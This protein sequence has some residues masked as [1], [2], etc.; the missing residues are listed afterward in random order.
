MGTIYIDLSSRTLTLKV[1]NQNKGHFPVAIGKQSTPTP[2]GDFKILSKIRN[3]GGVLGTRW[4]KFTHREHGIHG[5]NQPQLIG[6]AVSNGCVRMYNRDAEKVYGSVKINSPVIIRNRLSS[7]IE[8]SS[9]WFI[10]TVKPGDTL[11]KLSRKY[12]TT[13]ARLKKINHLNNQLLHPGQKIKIPGNQ[14]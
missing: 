10:Y 8:D 7:R 9:D 6:Q 13:V 1:N 14:A 5:T 12:N 4:M 2:E 11:W 3:P